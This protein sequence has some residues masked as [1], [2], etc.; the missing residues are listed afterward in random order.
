MKIYSIR[1][2]FL[3][4]YMTPFVGESDQ[5][6]IAAVAALINNGETNDAL[7]KAP[8]HFEIW[9]LAEVNDKTGEVTADRN[10]ICDCTSLIRGGVRHSG[11][12]GNPEAAGTARPGQGE[13]GVPGERSSAT[14][15]AIADAMEPADGTPEN[16]R[17]EA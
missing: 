12:K 2:R 8:Q 13:P 16:A 15:R 7:T 5:P 11:L 17:S 4:Y 9:R 10:F 1:D 14:Q 3:D 6:V